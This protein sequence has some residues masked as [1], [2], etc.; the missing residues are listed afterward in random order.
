MSDSTVA[1]FETV[2]DYPFQREW[3]QAQSEPL[4][5][6]SG[7]SLFGNKKPSPLAI[8]RLPERKQETLNER[9]EK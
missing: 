1:N 7:G 9:K 6:F 2:A 3:E 5:E 4:P 8:D